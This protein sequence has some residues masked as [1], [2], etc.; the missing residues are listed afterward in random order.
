MDVSNWWLLGNGEV[1]EGYVKRELF[2]VEIE[3]YRRVVKAIERTM[4][5]QRVV[6][7][8]YVWDV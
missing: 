8:V 5:V 4:E 6:E 7:E 1:F 3:H 2:K